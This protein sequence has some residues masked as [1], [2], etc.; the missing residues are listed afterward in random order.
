MKIEILQNYKKNKNINTIKKK[1]EYNK[2]YCNND[3]KRLKDNYYIN[4]NSHMN[5]I[6]Y[7]KM[8][9]LKCQEDYIT[10]NKHLEEIKKEE[11]N[12]KINK[13]E[14]IEKIL[15]LRKKLN[16]KKNADLINK[17]NNLSLDDSL[18]DKTINDVSFNDYSILKDTLK[19]GMNLIN[20]N[21]NNTKNNN[22]INKQI[23]TENKIIKMNKQQINFFKAKFISD[24]NNNKHGK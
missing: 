11:L 5:Q 21:I 17:D 16:D 19:L 6:K 4:I 1:I 14:L 3:L 18:E 23:F 13:M 24:V 7:M 9:L 15:F 8:K 20:I 10:I 2:I 22:K 12:F